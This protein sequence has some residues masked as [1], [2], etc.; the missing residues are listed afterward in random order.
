MKGAKAANLLPGQGTVALMGRLV[1]EH[2]R[3]Y[4]AHIGLALVFMVLTAGAT[5]ALAYLM[6]PIIDDVF[7]EKDRAMLFIIAFSVFGVFVLKGTATYGQ[8]VLMNYVGQR[9]IADLQLRMFAHL[10]RLDLAFFHGTSTGQL[11]SRFTNDLALVRGAAADLLVS[12]GKDLLT[13]V[14]LMAVMFSRDWMLAAVSFFVFPLAILPIVKIGRR[15]RKV[16]A[17]TQAEMAHF[18]SLLGETFQGARH[19][20]A[21][22]M[23]AYETG[24]A[25]RMIDAIFRL[26]YKAGRVRGAAHPIMETLGGVAIAVVILYGGWR[27][28]EGGQTAGDFLSFVTAL[29]LAYEPMKKLANL[30][31]GLQTGLAAAERVFAILDVEPEIGDKAGAG[32]IEVTGGAIEFKDVTFAYGPDNPALKGIT[33]SVPAGKR[34]ALVG[35]SGG[36][37]ST[38]LNLIPRF[39]DVGGGSVTIDGADVRDVTLASLRANIAL[40]SQ[41][42]SLFN[43]TVRANIAY[44]KPG[45]AEADVIAAARNA[46]AHDFITDLAAGYDTVAGEH[47]VKLS[48]GERQRVAI[49]RAMAKDAPI[50]LLDEATSAL[51]A[52]SERAVQAGLNRLMEGRTTLVIAHRLS[53]VIGADLIYVIEDGTVI[54]SGTHAEL[55]AK[56]G[57]YAALY[58]LQFAK[59]APADEAARARA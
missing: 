41:E 33:L 24:R 38:I 57:S 1:R 18:T 43:D 34:V 51:D 20:R 36:G 47:G 2:I 39:Y 4:F 16:S 55:L 25:K 22:G 46:A 29:L 37:K 12:A 27:V 7:V 9:I 48:G 49:A 17:S 54:E 40:V 5:A 44:G 10:M 53:T 52:H 59:E 42:I 11:V 56:G 31:A 30:N 15:M 8:A 3:H 50:L 28:I 26:L 23:E 58:E 45:C 14:F 13:L 21:Y 6:K 35:H 32:A 19:V